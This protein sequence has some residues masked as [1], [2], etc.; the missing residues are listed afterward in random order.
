MALGSILTSST[1]CKEIKAS[2]TLKLACCN[3]KGVKCKQCNLSR[4]RRTNSCDAQQRTA[5]RPFWIEL[6]R[7]SSHKHAYS[8]LQYS[9]GKWE[10]C[11]WGWCSSKSVELNRRFALPN[12][13]WDDFG[14]LTRRRIWIR[15]LVKKKAEWKCGHGRIER[16]LNKSLKDL[17]WKSHLM[18]KIGCP[19]H[20]MEEYHQHRFDRMYLT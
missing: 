16:V 6:Q 12:H 20:L 14:P 19:F 10:R 18:W 13:F 9:N 3:W 1:C 17:H 11:S 7:G 8:V 2:E 15:V 4:G 5:R